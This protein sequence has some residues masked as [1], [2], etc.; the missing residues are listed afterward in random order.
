M[1]TQLFRFI[2]AE[3]FLNLPDFFS[4]REITHSI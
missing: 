1:L 4:G 2:P 3:A